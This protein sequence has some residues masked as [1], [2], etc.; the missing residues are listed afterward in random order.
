MRSQFTSTEDDLFLQPERLHEYVCPNKCT[1]HT[2][3]NRYYKLNTGVYACYQ[4]RVNYFHP[5]LISLDPLDLDITS[6]LWL[7][8]FLQSH[9]AKCQVISDFCGPT[10]Y[11][12]CP[13]AD[14][15]FFNFHPSCNYCARGVVSCETPCT[16]S[17]HLE[18]R[19]KKHSSINTSCKYTYHCK[20]SQHQVSIMLTGSSS[21]SRVQC[22]FQRAI[23]MQNQMT[24]CHQSICASR[25]HTSSSG[26]WLYASCNLP[27][28]SSKAR[29]LLSWIS[30]IIASAWVWGPNIGPC[31]STSIGSG[32]IGSELAINSSTKV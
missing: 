11:I 25:L 1:C 17:H 7:G 12:T 23:P 9:Y 4:R 19:C 28:S 20:W 30:S 21:H 15:H 31:W 27:L 13:G 5:A 24:L 10:S 29:A 16:H 32:P 14:P 18:Y 2:D 3:K 6:P 22:K 8:D 26:P